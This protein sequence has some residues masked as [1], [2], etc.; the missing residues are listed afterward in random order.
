MTA[1]SI[2]DSRLALSKS[3]SVKSTSSGEVD[4][5]KPANKAALKHI[6]QS[7]LEV[8]ESVVRAEGE[9]RTTAFVWWLVIAAATGGLL[10]GYDVRLATPSIL[11]CSARRSDRLCACRPVSSAALSSTRI[12][13]KTCIVTLSALA[14]K[15]SVPP[16]FAD[17][18]TLLL[19]L[20]CSDS[21]S[22]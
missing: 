11:L 3:D 15:R 14:T 19:T 18:S 13:T 4:Y 5:T 7:S 17:E 9:E 21:T 20:Q 2:E 1:S 16:A 8:D 6:S 10:F 12:S 22:S